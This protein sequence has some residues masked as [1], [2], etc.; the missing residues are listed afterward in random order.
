MIN[1]AHTEPNPWQ[2]ILISLRATHSACL[3]GQ[4]TILHVHSVTTKNMGHVV[5]SLLKLSHLHSNVFLKA[6]I[7]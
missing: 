7:S 6:Y 5:K 4:N 1:Y 3:N 2:R